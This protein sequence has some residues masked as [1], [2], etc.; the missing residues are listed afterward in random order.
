MTDDGPFTIGEAA[1]LTGLSVHALR[2]YERE[3]L[4]VGVVPRTTGGRRRYTRLDIDWLGVCTSLRATGM[5][6][7]KIKEFAALVREGPG[8]EADRLELLREHQARVQQ[9][10]EALTT[11]LD[12]VRWK[13]EVYRAHLADGTAVGLWDPTASARHP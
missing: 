5:P 7:T 1:H 13:I 9:Q 10:I 3:D 2:F 8:N 4:L 12:L 11:G 6:L